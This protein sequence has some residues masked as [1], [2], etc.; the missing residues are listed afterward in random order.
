MAEVGLKQFSAEQTTKTSDRGERNGGD[1]TN[2]NNSSNAR[3]SRSSPQGEFTKAD[4]ANEALEPQAA[5]SGASAA[6]AASAASEESKEGLFVT[7][8]EQEW[9]VLLALFSSNLFFA[10][11]GPGRNNDHYDSVD[12][13]EEKGKDGESG[14]KTG[15]GTH[16]RLKTP[17]DD[18]QDRRRGDTED[19]EETTLE[20]SV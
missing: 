9:E 3:P 13:H 1:G 16:D 17:K 7:G 10:T 8:G 4:S 14:K 6:S 11:K 18:I 12:D 15:D 5:D 20:R 2:D 19:R